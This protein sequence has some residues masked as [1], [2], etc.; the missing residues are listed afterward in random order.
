M[1][2][3]SL[4][5]LAYKAAHLLVERLGAQEALRTTLHERVSARRARNRKRFT[6]WAAVATEIEAL[7]PLLLRNDDS[8]HDYRRDQVDLRRARRSTNVSTRRRRPGRP[9]PA[10]PLG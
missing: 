10:A 5:M 8:A 6:F 3:I 9:K 2:V 4:H 7:K 1:S